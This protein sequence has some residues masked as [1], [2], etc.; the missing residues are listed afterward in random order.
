MKPA[1]SPKVEWVSIDGIWKYQ[2]S[3]GK[4]TLLWLRKLGAFNIYEVYNL[5]DELIYVGEKPTEIIDMR[6]QSQPRKRKSKE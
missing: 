3:D 2:S 5:K 1:K 6:N 4:Y